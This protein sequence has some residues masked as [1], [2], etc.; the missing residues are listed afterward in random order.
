MSKDGYVLPDRRLR[1]LTADYERSYGRHD[2]EL[3]SGEIVIAIS[4]PDWEEYWKLLQ[5]NACSLTGTVLSPEL[6]TSQFELS[7]L[8]ERQRVIEQ[9]IAR[10]IDFSNDIPDVV[11]ALGTPV[12]DCCL[13][14]PTNSLL[15]I[16]G[17]SIVARKNK[18]YIHPDT[19]EEQAFRVDVHQGSSNLNTRTASL[20]CSDLINVAY[21]QS[22]RWPGVT[23]YSGSYDSSISD[24]TKVVLMAACW[25]MPLTQRGSAV[26]SVLPDE[27][28]YKSQLEGCASKLF[29]NHPRLTDLVIA[30]RIFKESEVAGPFNVHYRRA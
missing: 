23:N 19:Y 28:R 15:F 22:V 29:E 18:T 2:F 16:G 3:S 25:S 12:F 11:F 21:L 26:A 13:P 24:D 9:R 17:G 1:G 6:I 14:R 20:V 10:I 5:E 7:D 27:Q 30:D 8:C 4:A